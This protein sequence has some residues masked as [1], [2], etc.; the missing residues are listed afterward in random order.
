M[1]LGGGVRQLADEPFGGGTDSQGD[2]HVEHL[3][4]QVVEVLTDEGEKAKDSF[5]DLL[6]H[7]LGGSEAALLPTAHSALTLHAACHSLPVG[8]DVDHGVNVVGPDP[9]LH[10]TY[11]LVRHLC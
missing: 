6:T 4:A 7:L 9:T 5:P 11:A 3:I 8:C 2:G 1:W 10:T